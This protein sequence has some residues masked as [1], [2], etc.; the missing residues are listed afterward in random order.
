[1]ESDLRLRWVDGALHV[2]GEIDLANADRLEW[3]VAGWRP[4]RGA[5][6]L[7]LS[8][9]SFMDS[10]ACLVMLRVFFRR[11]RTAGMVLRNPSRTAGKVLALLRI[12]DTGIRIVTDSVPAAGR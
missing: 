12:E 1:M 7:D 9:I 4:S 10:S 11:A 8:Q 3:A 6:V 5:L 2:A